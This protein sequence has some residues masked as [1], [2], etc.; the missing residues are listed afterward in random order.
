MQREWERP[1]APDESFSHAPPEK[2]PSQKMIIVILFWTLFEHIMDRFFA[3]ATN[4]LPQGVR[5]DLLRRYSGIGSRLDR[6][7]RMLFDTTFQQ[8]LSALGYSDVYSHLLRVQEKRNEF[9]HGQAEAIDDGLVNDTVA[10]LHE[11]Q[12]AWVALFNQRCTGDPKAPPIW[13]A[14]QLTRG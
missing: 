6:L 9:V 4:T 10:K 14:D 3:V 5:N 1:I 11:V 7:Y 13:G 12:A 8:D 2:R